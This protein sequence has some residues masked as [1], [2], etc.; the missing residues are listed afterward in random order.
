M[1]VW[2]GLAPFVFG[3]CAILC[4][5]QASFHHKPDT[6]MWREM[7][8]KPRN[9]LFMPLALT[10]VGLRYRTASFFFVLL[11]FVSVIILG[12]LGR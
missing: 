9:L 8:F 5:S 11:T 7:R 10:R 1:P 12:C 4:A 2:F 3:I 6:D